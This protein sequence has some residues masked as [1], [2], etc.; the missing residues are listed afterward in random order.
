MKKRKVALIINPR[1]GQNVAKLLNILAVL[2]A[3]NCETK[4]MLKEYAAQTEELARQAAE[5]GY[6]LLLAYGGDGTLNQVVNGVMNADGKSTVGV[7]PGGTANLWATEI[8]IPTDDPVKAVLSLLDSEVRAVDVGHAVAT[9]L[10][11]PGNE[12]AIKGK[13][14][15]K[16][17]TQVARSHFLLMAGLGLDAMVMQ[18]VSKP[19]KHKIKQLAVGLSAAKGLPEYHPFPI[20]LRD[21]DHNLLWQGEAIQVIIGN[22]RLYADIFHMTPDAYIDDGQLDICVITSGNFLGTVQQIFSLL[23]RHQPDNVT[24]EFF[25][26]TRVYMKVPVPVALQ[27]DGSAIKLK[28]FLPKA[29]KQVLKSA[30]SL[31]GATIEYCFEAMSQALHVAVPRNY[32]NTLFEEGKPPE[33]PEAVAANSNASSNGASTSSEKLPVFSQLLE[34]LRQDGR[35]IKVTGSS[36]DAQNGTYIVAGTY[37]QA[38]TGAA[39]PV[40]VR[41]NSSTT[42]LNGDGE[43]LTPT[44]VRN[45]VPGSEVLVAGKKSERGAIAAQQLLI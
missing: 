39:K 25:K 29:Q 20:E 45:I 9:S 2:D 19:L 31:E 13:A 3:A 41:V 24:A 12:Q 6:D 26:G 35:K 21:R 30:E 42:I 36:F 18:G 1:E 22:T 5:D 10:S 38:G 43:K 7:L 37:T 4:V 17:K 33:K 34:K 28:D 8:G 14:K 16:A 27:F 15:K 44:A 40:A 23:L 32:D 11:F